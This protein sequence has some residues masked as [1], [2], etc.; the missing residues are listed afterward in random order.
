[1]NLFEYIA[2]HGS[3]INSEE[4]AAASGGEELLISMLRAASLRLFRDAN[5]MLVRVLRLL[6]CEGFV[7]EVGERT[8]AAT[9]VTA[10]MA[11]EPIAAGYRLM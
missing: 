7:K 5:G 11:A 8:W 10:V 9:P 4:L 6:A 3:P 2:G 1:M